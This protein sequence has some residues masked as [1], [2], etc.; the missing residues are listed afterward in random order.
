M[1][2]KITITVKSLLLIKANSVIDTS[3]SNLV[4]DVRLK[5][6]ETVQRLNILPIKSNAVLNVTALHC[7]A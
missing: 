2:K 7:M 3:A 5:I 6:K 4:A 1:Y